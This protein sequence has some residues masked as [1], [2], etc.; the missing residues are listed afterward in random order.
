MQLVGQSIT[1]S[2]AYMQVPGSQELP[3]QPFNSYVTAQ[4][5]A[6]YSQRLVT[7]FQLTLLKMGIFQN[8]LDLSQN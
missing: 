7:A 3:Q 8:I 2:G 4:M 6:V 1:L 5:L